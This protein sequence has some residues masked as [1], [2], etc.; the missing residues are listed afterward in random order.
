VL[1][2]GMWN[3]YQSRVRAISHVSARTTEMAK[4]KIRNQIWEKVEKIFYDTPAERLF[5]VFELRK[6]VVG[7][8][9]DIEGGYV[10][11]RHTGIRMANKTSE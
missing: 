8:I 6:V 2:L 5:N 1:D 9:I 10:A 11:P 4:N 3:S 7:D